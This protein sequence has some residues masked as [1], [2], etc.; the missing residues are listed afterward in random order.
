M[1]TRFIPHSVPS[2]AAQTVLRDLEKQFPDYSYKEAA[3]NPTNPADRANTWE[4]DVIQACRLFE[5][6]CRRHAAA[7]DAQGAAV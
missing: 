2:F 7:R 6:D 4:A 5:R 1:K 3:L